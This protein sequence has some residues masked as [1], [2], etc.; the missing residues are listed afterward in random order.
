MLSSMWSSLSPPAAFSLILFAIVVGGS[1]LVLYC[2]RQFE[3]WLA[4][5]KNKLEN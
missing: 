4:A 3:K 1:S 5:R 2:D